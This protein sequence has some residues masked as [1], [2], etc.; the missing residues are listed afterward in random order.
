R[1]RSEKPGLLGRSTSLTIVQRDWE[2]AR[3][4]GN[5]AVQAAIAGHGGSM[6]TLDRGPGPEYHI[7]TGL[8]PLSRVAFLER[9]FPAEWRSDEH[10]SQHFFEYVAPLAGEI[11]GFPALNPAVIA[12]MTPGGT[13]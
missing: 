11:A 8:A 6:I 4:C 3:L 13:I 2:E 12:K 9:P 5:A 1:A 10:L 7:A